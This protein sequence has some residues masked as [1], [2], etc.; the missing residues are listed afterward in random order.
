V[1]T[2]RPKY[3]P[4]GVTIAR[5]QLPTMIGV[6]ADSLIAAFFL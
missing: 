6:R 2:R 1:H 3:D 5:E 4:V